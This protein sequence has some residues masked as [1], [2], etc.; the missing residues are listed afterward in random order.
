MVQAG[1]KLYVADR[2][3]WRKWLAKNHDRKKGIWLIYYKK[4]TGKPRIPYE[5]AVEEAICFGWID[6]TVKKIDEEKYAQK[7]TPRKS[8]S[9]WSELNKKR[10][11][12]MIKLGKMTEAGLV[13]I[14]EAKE[15]GEWY[16]EAPKSQFPAV[17]LEFKKALAASKKAR[18]YFNSLAPSYRK[19]YIGWIAAARREETR[20]NRVMEAVSLLE[21][22]QKLGM[23]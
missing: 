5:D 2:E 21:Q 3:E 9:R 16:K 11:E 14:R 4:H 23:K 8:R 17:P 12:K 6:S 22:N 20:K 7:F 15:N 1:E 18:E 10:A 19:Q 13:K